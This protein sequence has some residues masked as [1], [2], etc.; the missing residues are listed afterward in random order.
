[1]RNIGTSPEY[2]KRFVSP[3][4]PGLRQPFR[5]ASHSQGA[6]SPCSG[7]YR[8]SA[9]ACPPYRATF[10]QNRV[11]SSE[12]VAGAWLPRERGRFAI[13]TP[14]HGGCMARKVMTWYSDLSYLRSDLWGQEDILARP[15]SSRYPATSSAA[16]Q[17]SWK[18]CPSIPQTLDSREATDDKRRC[19]GPSAPSNFL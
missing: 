6:G 1:M 5:T 9:E 3:D 2:H 14:L 10:R 17:K 8:S 13:A 16:P 11:V 4:S 19:T 12:R 7:A 18:S 15:V